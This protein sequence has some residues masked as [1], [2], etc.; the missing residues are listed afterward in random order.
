MKNILLIILLLL[1]FLGCAHRPATRT[2]QVQDSYSETSEVAPVRKEGKF[3]R[4]LRAF[5][6]G[7][8]EAQKAKEPN[9]DAY[10]RSSRIGNY[11]TTTCR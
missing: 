1:S 6:K 10:C 7:F 8:S 11:I 5:G 3:K 2:A 9:Q 4:A